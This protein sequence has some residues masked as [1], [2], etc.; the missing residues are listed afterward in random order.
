MEERISTGEFLSLDPNIPVWRTDITTGNGSDNTE[1]QSCYA[2]IFALNSLNLLLALVGWGGN[3]T[4]LWLLGFNV[5]RNPFTVY[6]LNLAGA[7]L[8]FLCFRI[9]YSSIIVMSS[10]TT[11]TFIPMFFHD[12]SNFAYLAGLSLL[13]AI[14]TERCLSV[15]WPIWY[16]CHRPRHTSATVCGLLWAVSLVFSLL[17][18]NACGH[19]YKAYDHDRC[20]AFSS[21]TTVWVIVSF[22]VLCGSSLA[23]LLRIVCGS[24]QWPVSRLYVTIMLTVLV[25][26]LFG[27]PLGT[28]WFPIIWI[29]IYYGH[30]CCPYLVTVVLSCVNSCA[31]PIIYF[32]VGSFRHCRFQRR[33]LKLILQRAMQDTPEDRE[34]RHRGSSGDPRELET[35]SSRS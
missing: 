1:T 27:L 34:C 23:L 21:V 29:N 4:V 12:I 31:N 16:R 8:L 33:T 5:G 17:E 3:A 24:R 20:Q 28:Q 22:V 35:V 30:P 18:G 13:S 26:L 25:F 2:Q 7:D 9:M 15:L 32:F 19:L 11:F 6:I 14:S 10:H